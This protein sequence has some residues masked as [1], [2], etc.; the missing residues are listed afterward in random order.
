MRQIL[1][2]AATVMLILGSGAGQAARAQDQE[3]YKA[4]K[5]V[6]APV[7]LREV[8]PTYTED[9][10]RRRVQGSVEVSAVVK[11]DGTVGEVV[12]TK[13]LDPDLDEQAV[14]ATRQWEFRPGTKDGKAVNVKVTIELTF[15]LRK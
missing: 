9:A 6:K 5:D 1:T 4:G 2:L 13:S 12:V 8:K 11:S 3:V 10:M 7:V 14:K 15:T